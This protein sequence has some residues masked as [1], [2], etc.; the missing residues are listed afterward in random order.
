VNPQGAMTEAVR[1]LIWDLDET[2]WHGT[3]TEGGFTYRPE[4]HDIVVT[5]AQ[6]GIFS[7]ICSKNDYETIKAILIAHD[8]WDYFVLP[9]INWAPKG[10]RLKSLIETIGLRP[11][12][13]RFIDD[14]HLNLREAKHHVPDLQIADQ[15]TI[16]GLLSDPLLAGKDDQALTRLHQYKRLERRVQAAAAAPGG[17]AAFLRES[18][19]EVEIEFDV[20]KHIDRAV[21]LINRTNQLN[22]TKRRLSEDPAE[23]RAQLAGRIAR[24]DTQAGLIKVTDRFG[25]HGYAGFYLMD[26]LP[27]GERRLVDFCFS[28]RI[29]GMN[30]EQWIYRRLGRPALRVVGEVIADVTDEAIEIDWI[31]LKSAAPAATGEPEEAADLP[32]LLARGGCNLAA[33]THYF[34]L[35][36]K[37]VVA[38]WN[39]LRAGISIRADH[40]LIMRY[41]AAGLPDDRLN[42]LAR[43]GY[44][45]QDFESLVLGR[46]SPSGV[47]RLV[48]FWAD[49]EVPLY[50][51]RES[52][53][54]IPFWLVGAQQHDLT[55]WSSETFLAGV[56][57]PEARAALDVLRTEFECIG[58]QTETMLEENLAW[59]FSS[60]PAKGPMFVLLP[61]DTAAN[62]VRHPGNA[63][64][65]RS[66][67]AVSARYR[68]VRLVDVKHFIKTA[69]DLH[70]INHFDRMVYFR[71]YEYL[72]DNIRNAGATAE[73]FTSAEILPV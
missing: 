9:S 61:N 11:A 54:I 41:A 2:F 71:L 44:L 60:V 56:N 4:C 21:E 26:R 53:F 64:L 36:A 28:C 18:R 13:V 17:N 43:L 67:S 8:I 24:T 68:N 69:D 37:T 66:I 19:I 33:I 15:T 16:P 30:L 29:M 50:R 45:R 48:S 5:L 59:I 14:N 6:R 72:K 25:D 39:F 32:P 42:L 58:L 52:G 1:L 12:T 31:A 7:S 57:H 22:F 10:P 73:F 34:G 38:E 46:N 27:S 40:S 55:T 35:Y 62:G 47:V 23:A 70:D 65:R 3:L 63:H 51:H 20:L 49:A